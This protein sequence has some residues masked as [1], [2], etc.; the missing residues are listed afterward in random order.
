MSTSALEEWPALAAAKLSF[1]SSTANA[2]AASFVRHLGAE[3]AQEHDPAAHRRLSQVCQAAQ[4]LF[5]ARCPTCPDTASSTVLGMCALMLSTY[6]QLAAELGDPAGATELVQRSFDHAYQAFIQNICKPL[7]HNDSRSPQALAGMNF[8]AW[9]ERLCP[10]EQ[11]R[12]RWAREDDITGYHHFFM[13]QGEPALAQIIQRAD[14]AWIAA[15]ASY[16]PS[17]RCDSRHTRASD[18]AATGEDG[19]VPFRFAPRSHGRTNPQTEVILELQ[20]H[21]EAGDRRSH[22]SGA[23]RRHHWSGVDRRQAGR[24][25]DDERAWQ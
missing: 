17:Q 7:L 8:R 21:A 10:R 2:W 16:G 1:R 19:F 15:V 3:L 6:R 12:L 11:Y 4:V 23:D 24:R 13:Q 9:S 18:A 5:N 20:L 14:Q 25:Q 22:A